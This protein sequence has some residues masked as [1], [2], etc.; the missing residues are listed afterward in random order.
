MK[1]ITKWE[2]GAAVILS[3]EWT[4]KGAI[5]I[6]A[7]NCRNIYC[8]CSSHVSHIEIAISINPQFKLFYVTLYLSANLFWRAR[9]FSFTSN[10]PLF[11]REKETQALNQTTHISEPS[12]QHFIP[13]RRW[14]FFLFISSKHH[15]NT[16]E[17]EY[18][19]H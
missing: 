4:I 13:F 14:S 1:E 16:S 11:S 5:E 6:S 19:L 8:S 15:V 7:L 9:A 10:I 12:L 3:C 18:V 2:F 17:N